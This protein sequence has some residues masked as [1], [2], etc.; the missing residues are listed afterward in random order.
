MTS[1]YRH[2][3]SSEIS[4]ESVS[5]KPGSITQI[6]ATP[7]NTYEDR[8]VYDISTVS[9]KPSANPID[10][11]VRKN[12]LIIDWCKRLET[13]LITKYSY[14]Q[15]KDP[16]QYE[17]YYFLSSL[18]LAKEAI[19]FLTIISAKPNVMFTEY[20]VAIPDTYT[21]LREAGTERY[22]CMIQMAAT[23]MTLCKHRI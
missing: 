16:N 2:N 3:T 22:P 9:F 5:V 20:Y 6:L 7:G 4:C 11:R 23:L 1:V 15:I 14:E 10:D 17:I 12:M 13:R 8:L 19:N 18:V 21:F